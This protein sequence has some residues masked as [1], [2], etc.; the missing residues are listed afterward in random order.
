MTRD[1]IKNM[2]PD[3]GAIKLKRKTILMS[4]KHKAVVAEFLD[5]VGVKYEAYKVVA[6][7][8]EMYYDHSTGEMLI[9]S[10]GVIF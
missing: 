8:E 7:E 1:E 3:F 4:L 5:L 10:D 2:E 9:I 6:G